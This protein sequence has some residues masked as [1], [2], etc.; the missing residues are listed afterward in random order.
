V[1]VLRAL[2]PA[3]RVERM[4]GGTLTE[5]LSILTAS[6]QDLLGAARGRR[7]VTYGPAAVFT[8]TTELIVDSA[9]PERT[10]AASGISETEATTRVPDLH[11]N[12]RR[13]V[14]STVDDRPGPFAERSPS[15]AR[16]ITRATSRR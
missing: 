16:S 6:C 13:T 2:V 10:G 7:V 14:I 5:V 12:V 8:L 4:A 1:C 3:A 11:A 9:P 15:S